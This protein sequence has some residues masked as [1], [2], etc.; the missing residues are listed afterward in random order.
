MF[1][2]LSIICERKSLYNIML[3]RATFERGDR[4]NEGITWLSFF[5]SLSIYDTI[6][7][8]LLLIL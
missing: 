4:L 3:T 5:A 8:I 1:N 2:E 6:S 7:T